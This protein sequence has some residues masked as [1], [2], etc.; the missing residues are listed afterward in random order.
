MKRL[1]LLILVAGA[2]ASMAFASAIDITLH[3][4]GDP[5]IEL[6][7]ILNQWITPGTDGTTYSSPGT[8]TD[9]FGALDLKNDGIS[10]S[11][12]EIFAYGKVGTSTYTPSC[13][14]GSGY[15]TTFTCSAPTAQAA[16]STI[17]QSSPIVW[18]FTAD[19]SGDDILNGTEFKL[20][21]TSSDSGTAMFYEIEINGNP[22][23]VTPEPTTIPFL[24]GGLILMGWAVRRKLNRAS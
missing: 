9:E 4:T 13:T 16:G 1:A 18:T 17:S 14:D 23:T 7:S 11:S 3:S 12:I 24:A 15:N 8:G 22:S 10:I 5:F 20:V 21:D 2:F 6:S 19:A